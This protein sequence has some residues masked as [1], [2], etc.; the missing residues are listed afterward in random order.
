MMKQKVVRKCLVVAKNVDF[1]TAKNCNNL[2]KKIYENILNV[3][4]DNL[5]S[6]STLRLNERLQTNLNKILPEY[7]HE[8]I[9][10]ACLLSVDQKTNL[11]NQKIHGCWL[12]DPDMI[13]Y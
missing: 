3:M 11:P 1:L 12:S 5:L 8:E 2:F 9:V 6:T 7:W 13:N 10:N 4:F